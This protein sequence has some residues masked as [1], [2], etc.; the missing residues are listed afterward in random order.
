MKLAMRAAQQEPRL[1]LTTYH[2][3][4]V[5]AAGRRASDK[6]NLPPF[7]DG[8]IRRE[9]DLEHEWPSI[10]C[11]CRG[12][13]F[14][15]RLRVGDHVVYMTVKRRYGMQRR[16]WRL[17]QVASAN[18]LGMLLTRMEAEFGMT[19]SARTRIQVPAGM[20]EMDEE[21]RRMFGDDGS[22]FRDFLRRSK[23]SS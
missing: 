12:E 3:L 8:A 19:P 20:G 16:H 15:P 2:P 5:T 10:T 13:Q 1:Y 11:L 23:E 22:A 9:P 21:D 4:V 17:P 7:V 18:K 6:H 14:A